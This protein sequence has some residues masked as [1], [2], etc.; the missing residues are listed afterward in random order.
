MSRHLL[1]IFSILLCSNQTALAANRLKVAVVV[2]NQYLSTNS[3]CPTRAF[4]ADRKLDK[5]WDISYIDF[6]ADEIE[7][8]KV[9]EHLVTKN[10][11]DVIIGDYTSQHAFA[12]GRV[13]DLHKVPYLTT[14]CSLVAVTEGRPFVARYDGSSKYY[15]SRY[16]RF[17]KQYLKAKSAAIVID[18]S[19]PFSVE[20]AKFV[21]ESLE[22]DIP[23]ITIDKYEIISADENIKAIAVKF[24]QKKRDVI[25]APLYA[26]EGKQ[27]IQALDDLK[28]TAPMILHNATLGS[29]GT[30]SKSFPIYFNGGTSPNADKD[31]MRDYSETIAKHCVGSSSI[32]TSDN[33]LASSAWDTISLLSKI[34]HAQPDIRGK[35]IIDAFN[36][37]LYQG[38]AGTR[39]IDKN[40]DFFLSSNFYERR[41][42]KSK[43]ILTYE[44]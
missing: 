40:G 44:D 3:V 12:I 6:P 41:D 14:T 28:S 21:K 37:G 27:L 19:K 22:K 31:K 16:S 32:S 18:V 4:I 35:A 1:A 8:S 26:F 13:F 15:A 9:A 39:F 20:Y 23:G 33:L 24:L 43:F 2:V 38:V 36:G 17:I 10:R 30:S 42:G 7:A 11:P 29:Q 5:E 34:M 25:Y